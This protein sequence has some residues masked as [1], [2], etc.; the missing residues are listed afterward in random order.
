MRKLFQVLL[1][2]FLGMGSAF[3]LISLSPRL[4]WVRNGA[5]RTSLVAGSTRAD[6][7]TRAIVAR[8]YLFILNRSEA[9]YFLADTDGEKPL[10]R[11]CTYRVQGGNLPAR[12]WSI[13]A[14]GEDHF[15][16][17]NSYGIYSLTSANVVKEGESWELYLSQEPRGKN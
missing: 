6:P 1:G 10:N 2:V 3:L 7:Y 9:M 14:Y 5:W 16:I 15:L 8:N 13:T 12:W 11:R 17:P 4:F